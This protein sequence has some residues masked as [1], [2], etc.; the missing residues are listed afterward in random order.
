M[1]ACMDARADG[2]RAEGFYRAGMLKFLNYLVFFH[3]IS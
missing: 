2:R 1:L 3:E